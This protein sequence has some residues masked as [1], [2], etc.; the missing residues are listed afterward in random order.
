MH[1]T[2]ALSAYVAHER[3]AALR[4]ATVEVRPAGLLLERALVLA[5]E[6]DHPIY[7]CVCLAVVRGAQVVSADRRLVDAARRHAALSEAIVFL[8][9]TAH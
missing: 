6:L 9:E 2:S 4:R 8:A 1:N 7:D 3:Y 5:V